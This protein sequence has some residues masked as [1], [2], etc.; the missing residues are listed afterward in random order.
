MHTQRG[1]FQMFMQGFYIQISLRSDV[2]SVDSGI[3][4]ESA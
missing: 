4:T 1:M 2:L 3:K